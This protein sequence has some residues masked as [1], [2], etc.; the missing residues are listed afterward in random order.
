[1]KD[2]ARINTTTLAF[3]GDAVYELFV[4]RRVTETG[5]Q[6][7]DRLHRAAVP[8]VCAE[9]QA[10]AVKAMYASL[11][12]DEQNLVRRARNHRS[13]SRP[14]HADALTYKWATAFEALVGYLYLAGDEARLNGVME[15]AA[16]ITEQEEV[17]H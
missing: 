8:Y 17:A 1:M 10:R 3:V 7:A 12:V 4:R 13:A 9:G 2:P 6:H 16:C 5:L 15:Q 14:R 11:S